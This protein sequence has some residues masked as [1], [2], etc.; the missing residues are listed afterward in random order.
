M[1]TTL[2][3]PGCDECYSCDPCV[4]DVLNGVWQGC[5]AIDTDWA[6]LP[7]DAIALPNAVVTI[8]G[9]CPPLSYNFGGSTGIPVGSG[10]D[11]SGVYSKACGPP[12]YND[13]RYAQVATISGSPFYYVINFSIGL[14]SAQNQATLSVRFASGYYYDT[15]GDIA[16]QAGKIVSLNPSPT[17]RTHNRV[18]TLQYLET[19]P[20]GQYRTEGSCRPE[21]NTELQGLKLPT[22]GNAIPLSTDVFTSPTSTPSENAYDTRV[23]TVSAVWA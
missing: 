15:V 13:L 4:C 18:A 12:A 23:P 19:R 21:C 6:N 5:T 1:V 16:V 11:F 2:L 22:S 20:Y 17:V 3:N 8:A 7:D 9:S 10:F 14:T